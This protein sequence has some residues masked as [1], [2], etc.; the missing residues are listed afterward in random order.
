MNTTTNLVKADILKLLNIS[1]ALYAEVVEQ[2]GY[3]FARHYTMDND[4]SVNYL[5]RTAAYWNWWKMQWQI[6][7]EVF[8]AEYGA[9]A[10]LGSDDDL[11]DWW[12]QH[13]SPER[14]EGYPNRYIVQQAWE[15]MVEEVDKEKGGKLC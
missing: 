5:T 8:I 15:L 11:F 10:G 14:V 12:L 3:R 2:T 6:C 7:D 9:Y 1:E 13:H 4:W